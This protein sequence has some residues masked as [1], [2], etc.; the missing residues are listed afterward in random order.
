MSWETI[1]HTTVDAAFV[2]LH[3]IHKIINCHLSPSRWQVTSWVLTAVISWLPYKARHPC[4]DYQTPG[5]GDTI[6][7]WWSHSLAPGRLNDSG[8]LSPWAL[9]NIFMSLLEESQTCERF[10][11]SMSPLEKCHMW[12]F[13]KYSFSLYYLKSVR[14][15][16][17]PS[18]TLCHFTV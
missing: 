9:L 10:W 11:F 15:G 17:F 8:H 18:Y 1:Q 7:T 3:W 6:H 12:A 4:L 14:P 13:P 16:L 2:Y 5:P